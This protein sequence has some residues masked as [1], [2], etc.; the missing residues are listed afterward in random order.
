MDNIRLEDL[1]PENHL[2]EIVRVPR[3]S[4]PPLKMMMIVDIARVSSAKLEVVMEVL[5]CSQSSYKRSDS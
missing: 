4:M 5:N 1:S 2:G 3:N